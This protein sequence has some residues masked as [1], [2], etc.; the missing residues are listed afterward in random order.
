VV[1][2]E[3]EKKEANSDEIL[4]RLDR[5]L[6]GLASVKTRIREIADLL[7]VDRLRPRGRAGPET[8]TR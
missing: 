7:V 3:A 6:I 1:D 8:S 4:D 5:E 2:V